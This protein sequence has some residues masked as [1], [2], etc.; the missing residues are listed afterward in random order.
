MTKNP[1]SASREQTAEADF[2]RVRIG[3]YLQVLFLIHVGFLAVSA[4]QFMLGLERIS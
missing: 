2:Q 3:L 4:I 1:T